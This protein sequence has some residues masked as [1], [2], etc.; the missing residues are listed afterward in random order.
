MVA[1]TGT[2]KTIMGT[3]IL[4]NVSENKI[5]RVFVISPNDQIM[6]IWE[7][8]FLKFR[9]PFQGIKR[10]LFREQLGDWENRL[11]QLIQSIN[12]DDLIIIDGA[13]TSEM[14]VLV[15]QFV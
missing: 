14:K 5:S 6:D 13:I 9:I 11:K 12:E 4:E 2:G 7:K 15:E 8:E 1:L 3:V 10:S